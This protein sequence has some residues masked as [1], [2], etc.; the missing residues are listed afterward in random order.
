MSEVATV[1]TLTA[2]QAE[3]LED[4]FL[5]GLDEAQHAYERI[6][7]HE[8]WTLLGFETFTA[9]WADRVQ[10]MMRALS[11]RPTREIAAAVVERVREEEAE[12]PAAQRRT[13]RELANMVGVHP[14]TV[15]G[16]KRQD[17]DKAE[18]PP[19]PDLDMP[20]RQAAADAL[21]AALDNSW[22]R[23]APAAPLPPDLKRELDKQY[24]SV[25]PVNSIAV[26]CDLLLGRVAG[27]DPEAAVRNAPRE[28]L[29]KL[30][31]ARA[32][33]GF[34]TRVVDALQHEEVTA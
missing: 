30:A 23:P 27:I 24:A 14:D 6:V 12:L 15:S 31:A 8:A 21:L 18:V 33:L 22:P 7:E 19:S 4:A 11:M 1:Q 10:P 20:A 13:Q 2:E 17:P 34:L 28:M 29:P 16:R 32:A 25:G 26:G 3:S 9:W 5:G